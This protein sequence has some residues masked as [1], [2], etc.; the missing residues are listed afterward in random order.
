MT[1]F[2]PRHARL[3]FVDQCSHA[4]MMENPERFNQLLEEFLTLEEFAA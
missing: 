3:R 4:P 1:G 2:I